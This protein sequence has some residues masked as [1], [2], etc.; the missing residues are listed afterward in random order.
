MGIPDDVV[1]SAA[2]AGC[3]VG[4]ALAAYA[5]GWA[6]P[7]YLKLAPLG[8]YFAFA[9]TRRRELPEGVDTVGNWVA[10]AVGVAVL[11]LGVG[12]V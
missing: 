2:A 10:G 12:A 8:V 4:V 3:T 5:V 9:F 11:A 6:L 1:V 7:A